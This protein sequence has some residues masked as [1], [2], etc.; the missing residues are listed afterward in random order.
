MKKKQS[1]KWSIQIS[2]PTAI[3][4][5]E[6]CKDNGFKMNWF[7]ETAIHLCISSSAIISCVKSSFVPSGSYGK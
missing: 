4:L 6:Y 2:E 7:V 3:S 5:K 1:N